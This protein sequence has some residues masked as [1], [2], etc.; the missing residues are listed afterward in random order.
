MFENKATKWISRRY[1]MS[2]KDIDRQ[3]F[4]Y[5]FQKKVFS[6]AKK[7]C[8]SEELILKLYKPFHQSI[9]TIPQMRNTNNH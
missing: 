8:K 5:K 3:K 6:E 9:G 4:S 1:F 7:N 2:W